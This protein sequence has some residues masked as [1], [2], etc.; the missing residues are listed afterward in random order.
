MI[1]ASRRD[2]VQSVKRK[3]T[4]MTVDTRRKPSTGQLA[5]HSTI[6]DRP[7]LMQGSTVLTLT[8][9]QRS[10]MLQT[11]QNHHPII[12]LYP[13]PA[14]I[15]ALYTVLGLGFEHPADVD[16]VEI[17]AVD[18]E[19]DGSSWHISSYLPTDTIEE[20]R[21]LEPGEREANE[22]I[23]EGEDFEEA[24]EDIP[25]ETSGESEA[26]RLD[27]FLTWLSE[28]GSRA[29]GTSSKTV[30]LTSIATSHTDQVVWT[31]EDNS[32]SFNHFVYSTHQ[33]AENT[34]WYYI[35]QFGMLANSNAY[36]HDSG[37]DKGYYAVYFHM[38]NTISDVDTGDVNS[39]QCAPETHTGTT[40]YT[41]GVSQS[42]GGSVSS[43]G[44]EISGGVTVSHQQTVSV[45]DVDIT[46]DSS[47]SSCYVKYSIGSPSIVDDSCDNSIHSPHS[48]TH[49]TFQPK[50]L[51]L[52]AINSDARS[53]STGF[54]MN[55]EFAATLKKSK[56]GDCNVFGCNCDIN[57]Y[58]HRTTL[59]HAVPLA[60]PPECD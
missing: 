35:E 59:N 48:I 45:P 28:N 6:A 33:C 36:D 9:S 46:N 47:F 27:Y 17:F 8:E 2:K 5:A 14:E 1:A 13:E 10:L 7:T 54:V 40:N 16:G 44:P 57:T 37:T 31:F 50:N 39:I 51:W 41:Y 23:T 12:L 52:V 43:D 34:D 42:I 32:Y 3:I 21:I 18:L 25:H 53:G 22:E 24:S 19:S 26:D 58:Y 29:P 38:E 55:L 60:F 20:E 11:Y 15:T 49:S 56:I 4:L 30:D